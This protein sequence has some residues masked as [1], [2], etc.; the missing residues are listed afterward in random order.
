MGCRPTGDLTEGKE[1]GWNLP[2]ICPSATNI[3]R[4]HLVELTAANCFLTIIIQT[5]IAGVEMFGHVYI[6]ISLSCHSFIIVFSA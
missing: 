1:K 4:H 3:Q 5:I 6:H 2:L